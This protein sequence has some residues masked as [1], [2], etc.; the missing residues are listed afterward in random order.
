MCFNSFPHRLI[1][2]NENYTRSEMKKL[3]C[4]MLKTRNTIGKGEPFV[5]RVLCLFNQKKRGPR[6]FPASSVYYLK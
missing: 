5:N 6:K 3:Q 1:R 4:M 2:I